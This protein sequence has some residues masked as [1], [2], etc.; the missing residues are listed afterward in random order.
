MIPRSSVLGLTERAVY[1]SPVLDR[2]SLLFAKKRHLVLTDQGRLLCIK[3]AKNKVKVKMEMRL[4]RSLPTSVENGETFAG[5]D[6][7]VAPVRVEEDS[8]KVFSLHPVRTLFFR[9]KG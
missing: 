4:G 6:F 5:G 7:F 9:Q 8:P 2:S 3:E 1:T